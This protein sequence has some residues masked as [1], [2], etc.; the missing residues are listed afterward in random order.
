MAA[1]HTAI[2]G[3]GDVPSVGLLVAVALY[4]YA[5]HIAMRQPQQDIMA[6]DEVSEGATVSDKRLRK[7]DTERE[8]E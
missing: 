6:A 1:G 5:I 4:M 7:G 2:F 8:G 3:A